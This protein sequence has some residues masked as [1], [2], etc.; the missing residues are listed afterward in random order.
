MNCSLPVQT[1][2]ID[3]RILGYHHGQLDYHSIAGS[4]RSK[5]HSAASVKFLLWLSMVSKI[6]NWQGSSSQ[7]R[8]TDSVFCT[9]THT[10]TYAMV[11][12]LKINC[13]I[14]PVHMQVFKACRISN[15]FVCKTQNAKLSIIPRHWLEYN[16][17]NDM[18]RLNRIIE[19]NI[20]RP[21]SGIPT[22]IMTTLKDLRAVL[23]CHTLSNPYWRKP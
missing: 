1:Q 19:A 22:S 20:N 3:P 21:G 8:L 13:I 15:G 14:Y 7:L 5:V 16:P 18:H 12:G 2:A 9:H 6:N 4:R 23:S 17:R 10:H 11:D